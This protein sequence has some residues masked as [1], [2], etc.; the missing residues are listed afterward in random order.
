MGKKKYL[1]IEEHLEDLDIDTFDGEIDQLV[2]KLDEIQSKHQDKYHSLRIGIENY[3]DNVDAILYGK[4]SE[5]EQ[6]RLKRLAK[7]RKLRED[8]KSL[9]AKR[10]AQERQQLK[11][12]LMKHGGDLH[13]D[14][15]KLMEEQ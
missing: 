10:D 4:R 13:F 5:T 15:H 3:H 2:K 11:E 7:A 1:E 6:E 12:L 8:K 9:K 14:I